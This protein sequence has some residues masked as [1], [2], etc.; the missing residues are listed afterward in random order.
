MDECQPPPAINRGGFR[1][2]EE[3]RDS[4]KT[5]RGENVSC[6]TQST[7]GA[8]DGSDAVNPKIMIVDDDAEVRVIVAEFLEDFGYAVVQANGGAEAL[9]LLAQS[10]DLRM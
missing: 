7:T 4:S 1:L 9:E 10:P 2:T 3:F 6:S 8:S 5:A